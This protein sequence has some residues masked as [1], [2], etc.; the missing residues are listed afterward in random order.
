MT[1]HLQDYETESFI[2]DSSLTSKAGVN[3]SLNLIQI[4]TREKILAI[5][6]G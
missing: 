6:M 3:A 2:E 1:K 4:R 5:R